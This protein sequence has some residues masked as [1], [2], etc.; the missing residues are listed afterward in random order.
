MS[1]SLWKTDDPAFRERLAGLKRQ[2]SLDEGLKAPA[3]EGEPPREAVRRIIED[4]RRRGD[5]AVLE[6][7]ERFDGC[8]LEAGQ[9]RVRPD[10]IEAALARCPDDLLAV[11]RKAADRIERFQRAMLLQDPE[12]LREGGR[13]L[14]VRYRPVDSAA[15]YAPGAAASLASSVLMSAVPAKVAGVPRVV[16]ATPARPDGTISDDR[17]VAAHVAGVHEIYR[18]GGAVAVAAL[19]YG[20]ETVPAVD[21]IAGPGNI[22]LALAKKEVFGQVGI[23]MLPGPSEVIVIADGSADARWLA[24]DLIAQAEHN[25]GS[26]ILLTPSEELA[27]RVVEAVE[28]QLADLPGAGEARGCLERYGAVIVAESMDE[29][30]RL[31]NELAPEHL[32]IVTERPEDVLAGIRHAGAVFLGP[33]TPV[34]AGDYIAGPSHVLPTGTTARFSSGLS[35]NDFLKRFSVISYD[36]PALGE[37][38][39]DIARMARSEG[40]EGHARSVELRAPRGDTVQGV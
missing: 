8:A 15:V 14:A 26:A 21:F 5:Q 23:E 36:R 34:A 16:L 27:R 10:E 12:P 7:T 22:Y 17:L 18:L 20:T 11:L 37:D 33:W 2:L 6:Y 24:A 4:V 19:A 39:P 28:A 31:T 13:T 25:P 40:L 32:E 9:L 30:V 38:A 29:C 3:H 1:L 35:A